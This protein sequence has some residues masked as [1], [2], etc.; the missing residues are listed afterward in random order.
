MS[1]FENKD[2]FL[3]K[4]AGRVFVALT[5]FSC[6]MPVMHLCEYPHNTKALSQWAGG[7]QVPS[8]SVVKLRLMARDMLVLGENRFLFSQRCNIV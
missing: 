4:I 5:F 8:D 1:S 3:N 6:P 2:F 7:A